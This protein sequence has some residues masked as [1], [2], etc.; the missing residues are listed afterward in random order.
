MVK[1][2][3]KACNC[4]KISNG[5]FRKTSTH[6]FLVFNPHF[7]CW[8]RNQCI[9]IIAGWKFGI[10]SSSFRNKEFLQARNKNFTEIEFVVPI[11]MKYEKCNVLYV[12][13]NLV[14]METW[15]PL[16]SA[17]FCMISCTKNPFG[18]IKPEDPLM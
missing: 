7:I 3:S 2:K 13:M 18:P 10:K 6:T 4:G 16:W 15:V 9:E 8:F 5:Q 17:R 1:I 12:E 11:S 14:C